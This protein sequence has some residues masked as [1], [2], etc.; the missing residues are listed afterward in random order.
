MFI[1]YLKVREK[2]AKKKNLNY[3]F[4]CRG[5]RL[6]AGVEKNNVKILD[7]KCCTI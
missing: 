6:G 2:T 4:A 7:F 3:A 1:M 5:S